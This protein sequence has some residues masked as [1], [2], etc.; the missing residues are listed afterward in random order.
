MAAA[1]N[2]GQGLWFCFRSEEAFR[3]EVCLALVLAPAALLMG[4]STVEK[5][6][7][8]SDCARA[9]NGD[10]QQRSGGRCR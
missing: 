4:N 5:V 2:S 1:R 10:A 8:A 9:V 7:A 3:L 6:L